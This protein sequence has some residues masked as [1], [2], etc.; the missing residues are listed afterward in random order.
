M[1]RFDFFETRELVKH[2]IHAE[3][4]ERALEQAFAEE[5]AGECSDRYR[6]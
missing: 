6:G 1:E 2:K 4:H 5:V 3:L